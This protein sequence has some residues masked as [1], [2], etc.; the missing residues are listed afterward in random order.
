MLSNLLGQLSDYNDN[1]SIYGDFNLDLLKASEN[2]FVTEYI[3]GVFSNG[4][5]Q[6]VLKPTRIAKN[7]A[8]LIDHILTN[9]KTTNHTSH[10]LCNKISDHF[11]MIHFLETAKPKLS[12][13]IKPTRNFSMCNV[14]KFKCAIKNYNWNHVMSENCPEKAY[15]NFSNTFNFLFDSFFPPKQ[16]KPNINF[17]PREPWMSSGLLIS[18]GRRAALCKNSIKHP[19]EC[20]ITLYKKYRNLYNQL[21]KLAKKITMKNNLSIIKKMVAKLGKSC[22][23]QSAKA[24]KTPIN[25]ALSWLLLGER[26]VTPPPWLDCLMNIFPKWLLRQ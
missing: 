20:N 8:T 1:V 16:V 24:K 17:N 14:N 21:I 19:T 23:P 3:N 11:P 6:I 13:I 9:S 5:L 7:S 26:S 22:I 12:N 2:K 18:R 15:T 10:I 25:I 4:F